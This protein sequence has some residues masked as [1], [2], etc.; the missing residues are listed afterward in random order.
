MIYLS[1]YSIL[2]HTCIIM[3]YKYFFLVFKF[4]KINYIHS[5]FIKL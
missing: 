2:I 5:D 4:D 1:K 3:Y